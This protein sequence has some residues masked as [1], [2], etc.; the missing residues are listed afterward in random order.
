[1]I[2]RALSAF[3]FLAALSAAPATA[4][5]VRSVYTDVDLQRCRIL[6]LIEEGGSVRRRCPG[7]GPVQLFVNEGDGR[8]DVD[9]GIDNDVWES[10]PGLNE[11]GGRIEWRLLGR[12]PFA[13]IYRL[14]LTATDQPPG[15]S[16]IVETI[17]RPG[18]PG[19]QIAT[20]DGALPDANARARAIADRQA[21]TFRCRAG[22]R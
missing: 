1:M 2:R 18:A 22:G 4:Q 16:L 3:G 17:G 6:E 19:C 14:R 20:V 9:A 12:R 21:R 7:L 8:F 10:L 5:N 13:I 15:S 11:I